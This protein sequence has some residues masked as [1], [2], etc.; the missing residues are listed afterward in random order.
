MAIWKVV[1]DHI[2][3]FPHPNSDRLL[4][5]TGTEPMVDINITHEYII[6]R[7]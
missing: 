4:I 6:V 1:A 7:A 5:G 3:L 2:K